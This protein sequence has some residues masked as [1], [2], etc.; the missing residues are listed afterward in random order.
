MRFRCLT[1]YYEYL[2]KAHILFHDEEL[3][4][5]WHQAYAQLTAYLKKG[6]WWVDVHMETGQIT[7]PVL[8][9]LSAFW[10]GL[11]VLAG[12]TTQAASTLFAYF[13]V[14]QKYARCGPRV[15][16]T[17]PFGTF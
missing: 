14:W 4:E 1:S 6:P 15:S 17:R 7:W 8:N 2:L 16:Q 5:V 12:D 3:H 13:N 11:Q 10:P 9:S